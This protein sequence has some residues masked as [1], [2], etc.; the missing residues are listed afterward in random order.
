MVKRALYTIACLNLLVLKLCF[1]LQDEDIYGEACPEALG[2]QAESSLESGPGAGALCAAG[3][4]TSEEDKES[5]EVSGEGCCSTGCEAQEEK[6]GI[7]EPHGPAALLISRE[8]RRLHDERPAELAFPSSTLPAQRPHELTGLRK[9]L[10]LGGHLASQPEAA[11]AGAADVSSYHIAAG[12]APWPGMSIGTEGEEEAS[13]PWPDLAVSHHSTAEAEARVFC[14]GAGSPG[15]QGS[16][17][18][19]SGGADEDAMGSPSPDSPL[20]FS[21]SS[22]AK[23]RRSKR[24]RGR[25][26]FNSSRSISSQESSPHA[27]AAA[28]VSSPFSHGLHTFVRS[29]R[30]AEQQQQ[31]HFGMGQASKPS[32]SSR[33]RAAGHP[34]L[35]V[36]SSLGSVGGVHGSSCDGNNPNPFAVLPPAQTQLLQQKAAATASWVAHGAA[37]G[38][39]ARPLASPFAAVSPLGQAAAGAEVAATRTHTA[40]SS[41]HSHVH[42]KFGRSRTFS[43]PERRAG[44]DQIKVAGQSTTSPTKSGAAG[45]P[46][47][48]ATAQAAWAALGTDSPNKHM[49]NSPHNAFLR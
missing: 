11:S 14:S 29:P 1:V 48:A 40:D 6:T 37:F 2:A 22:P 7:E 5:Q 38:S 45:S 25:T 44:A 21:Q 28:T 32:T 17:R 26:Y 9:R 23:A 33:P 12:D 13:M 41:S 46:A 16:P 27:H 24:G 35:T 39:N 18:W 36:Q 34:S 42:G 10:N 31:H 8:E 4:D 49:G 43:A 47:M 20:S 15:Q 30:W 19:P 3:L